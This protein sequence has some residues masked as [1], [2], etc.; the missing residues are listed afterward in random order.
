MSTL[1]AKLQQKPVPKQKSDF[2]IN[3][4]AQH[5]PEI[6]AVAEPGVVNVEEKEMP[7]MDIETQ[8]LGELK[9]VT[10]VVGM[11]REDKGESV[12]PE[13]EEDEPAQVAHVEH[14]P[15]TKII[16]KTKAG[17]KYDR[18]QLLERMRARKLVVP[19]MKTMV[20]K[21]IPAVVE[22]TAQKVPEGEP[23]IKPKAATKVK[24]TTD[25]SVAPKI[26]K[27]KKI[28]KKK[29]KLVLTEEPHV[30]KYSSDITKGS[31][32]GLQHEKPKRVIRR[33]TKPI[34]KTVVV[35]AP[36]SMVQMGEILEL[37]ERIQKKELNPILASS[38][39]LNNRETFV[40]FIN[41]LFMPYRE[42]I[43]A[44]DTEVSCT[45]KDGKTF[46]AFTHQ[47][48]VRDYLNIYSPYRGLLLY[49]GLGS[50][51]TCTSIGIAEGL[52]SEREVIIMTPASLRMNYIEQLKECGDIIYKKKQY[53]EFVNTETSPELI[54]PLSEAMNLS[55]VFIRKNGGAWLIDMRKESN[56]DALSNDEKTS[57]NTQLNEMIRMKYKFISYNGLRMS[58]IDNMTRGQTVNPF[59]NKVVII[60]E[61]HNFISRIVNKLGRSGSMSVLL[62]NYL[63][64]AENCRIVLL[65]GTPVINYPNEIGVL[66]N[67]L[68]GYIKTWEIPLNIKTSRKINEATL[69][70]IFER[71]GVMDYIQYT[72]S[73]KTMTVTRNPLGFVNKRSKGVYKGVRIAEKESNYVNDEDF[74]KFIVG[75]LKK[76]GIEVAAGGV[77][78]QL[79]KALPDTLDEFKRYFINDDGAVVNSGMFKKRVLGLTSYF[80]SAKEELMPQYNEHTDFHEVN[81][82]MSDYQFG[83]YE[84]ARQAERKQEKNSGK[85]RKTGVVQ[86]DLYSDTVSTY[87]IF[88]RAFCNFVFPP[89][90]K[91]PM[92]KDGEDIE[93]AAAQLNED[94]IDDKGVAERLDNP[95]GAFTEE[96]AAAFEGEQS[97]KQDVSYDERIKQALYYL[98]ENEDTILSPEGLETYS[99]KFLHVLENIRETFGSADKDGSHLIYSQFRTLEG[100]G[101]MKLVLEA[102][103]FAQFKIK[104]NESTGSWVVDMREEDMGKPTFA[105]YTGTET[106]EEK[107]IIR[108]I[109][110]SA[111]GYVP[112]SITDKLSLISSNNFYGEV[113]KVLMITASGAEGIDLKNIRHVHL[114]EPYWHPVRLEQVIGRAI[115]ICSHADLPEEHRNV[116]VYLYLMTFTEAQKTGDESIELRL[117]DTSRIDRATPLTSDE[118]LNEISNIKRDVNK[119]LL[120]A[121]KEAAIDCAIHTSTSSKEGLVCYSFG[122]PSVDKFATTPSYSHQEKDAESDMNKEK[123]TWKGKSFTFKGKK[124]I[125]RMEAD[126]KSMTDMVYDYDSFQQAKKNPAVNPIL[127]GRLVR[128][129]K[130]ARIVNE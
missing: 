43:L 57:L 27:K 26:V 121:V 2:Q 32:T 62:Y 52:K 18:A 24:P 60:D 78:V 61:A 31:I 77:R 17:I 55:E 93:E 42:E 70:D 33:K 125:L 106:A 98:K 47:K 129:G 38:Y 127:V 118:A 53:W 28:I 46:D 105:L 124:Y 100:I 116:Q 76:E 108:N 120:T 89:E 64:E 107:E 51:K 104:R 111:W 22:E 73:S 34:D 113:I 12:S 68:R 41:Q 122:E 95:D 44:D 130:K 58:H 87:R 79:Y 65:T 96:D 37:D 67:I 6:K 74:M 3:I 50:G 126:G 21:A 85:K 117:K 16:D 48:I 81:I 1:L 91:R 7:L 94:D 39:Y 4:S 90:M 83:I 8:P 59:D 114:M 72:P 71:F 40:N 36:A 69:K 123:I 66:F 54:K 84:K 128:E 119:Q 80:R 56:Y 82:P 14:P 45:K 23:E 11:P 13:D 19:T 63:L 49:H 109:F 9:D 97:A 115:R 15:Q 103:G 92:P 10:D 99:P 101:I 5:E 102:N 29:G 112:T 86:N 25:P 110:N 30:K 35:E 75:K 20:K 88:S